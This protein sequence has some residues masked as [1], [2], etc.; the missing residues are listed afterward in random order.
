[1]PV[2]IPIRVRFL[3]AVPSLAGGSVHFGCVP[4]RPP[5]TT[6]M[7]TAL[8]IGQS[9]CPRARVAAIS[10]SSLM[11]VLPGDDSLLY[12][13]VRSSRRENAPLLQ[14]I[15]EKETRHQPTGREVRW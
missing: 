9:T 4:S 11:P 7:L 5:V 15:P 3:P 1:M 8:L 12:L 14:R 6:E 10:N 2:L 13:S